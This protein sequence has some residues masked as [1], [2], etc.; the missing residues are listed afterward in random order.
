MTVLTAHQRPEG[1]PPRHVAIIMDGN[2]R[3]AQARGLPRAFGHKQGVAAVRRTVEAAADLGVGYLTLFGFSTENWKRPAAEVRDLVGLL[4]FFLRR[5]TAG[6]VRNGVRLRVIGD[7]TRFDDDV[8]AMIDTAEAATAANSRLHLTVALSY[9]A[10]QELARA[11]RKLAADVAA[12][13]LS[14]AAVD[15]RT[16]AGYLETRDLPDPD[17]VIRTSGEQRLSNFLLWQCAYAELVFDQ[18]MWPDFSRSHLEQAIATFRC[19]ERRYGA[20]V[21]T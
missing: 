15:E 4:K 8:V 20:V 21:G 18:V 13:R 10:R 9:G 19:R 6:L 7:R 12:G 16:L 3:W 2:G 11:A 14:A 5:E 17:L 1:A